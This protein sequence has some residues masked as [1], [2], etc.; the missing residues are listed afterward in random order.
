M[1]KNFRVRV[2]A[3]KAKLCFR[4]FFTQY[5][6]S[7]MGN[8]LSN[9]LL[10]LSFYD[11]AR[12]EI[13]ISKIIYEASPK[14]LMPTTLLLNFESK[15]Y[16]PC[17]S[18]ISKRIEIAV[19]K[20][21]IYSGMIL[22][23][24]PLSACVRVFRKGNKIRDM[25]IWVSRTS[26]ISIKV[27]QK[28]GTKRLRNTAAAWEFHVLCIYVANINQ[29]ALEVHGKGGYS[30]RLRFMTIESGEISTC[31]VLERETRCERLMSKQ[32][33]RMLYRLDKHAR[34]S[35]INIDTEF[36]MKI[37]SVKDIRTHTHLWDQRE[38]FINQKD[39]MLLPYDIE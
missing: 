10:N 16:F 27:D 7:N 22:I 17:F 1:L 24:P 18:H 20:K 12:G 30:T 13:K 39:L 11:C 34:L 2:Q 21:L 32:R 9:N 35:W 4:A 29:R 8:C 6:T 19:I 25:I 33:T 36:A 14:Q 23:F 15:I 3:P 37:T 28:K 26:E 38:I 31:D 5:F